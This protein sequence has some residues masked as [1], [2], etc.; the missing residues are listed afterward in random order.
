[1]ATFSSIIQNYYKQDKIFL[2]DKNNSFEFMTYAHNNKYITDINATFYYLYITQHIANKDNYNIIEIIKN[3]FKYLDNVLRNIFLPSLQKDEYL[4]IFTKLQR[5]YYGFARFAHIYKIKKATVQ[6]SA[7]LCMNE[8]N[9]K[10]SNIFTLYQNKFIYYFTASD[11]INMLNRNLSNTSSFSPDVIISKNPYN[12]IP[13]SDTVLYNIYFFLRGSMYVM[14]ELLHGFFLSNFDMIKFR[15]NYETTIINI[16]I[17]NFIYNSHYDTLYP[18]FESMFSTYRHITKKIQIDEEF[19]KDRLINIMRPYL[20]LY[21]IN[22]HTTDGTYKQCNAEYLLRKKL[23]LFVHF[24]P[25]FGRRYIKI[26]KI[27]FRKTKTEVKFDDKH[28]N[29]YKKNSTII[30]SYDF[31]DDENNSVIY[32]HDVYFN[33]MEQNQTPVLLSDEEDGEEEYAEANETTD[34][35]SEDTDD[36][37]V[38]DAEVDAAEVDDAEVDDAEVDDENN[39]DVVENMDVVLHDEEDETKEDDSIS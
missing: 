36:A 39:M 29:F 10:R 5:I 17:K 33:F 38:D 14:P 8:L 21:Y 3:K 4:T 12:N 34:D 9:P 23:R 27:F 35:D 31:E 24:N 6:I 25:K 15:D 18:I 37:E 11:L 1:M 20:H 30:H 22:L 13:F 2:L 19:P 7:D 32:S 26:H 28:I 16:Y